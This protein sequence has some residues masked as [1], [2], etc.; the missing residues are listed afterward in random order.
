[1]AKRPRKAKPAKLNAIK[2][3]VNKDKWEVPFLRLWG[4]MYPDLPMPKRDYAF[5]AGRR[6]KY[7]FAWPS[8]KVAV[9]L[10][11][12]GGKSRHTTVAGH[13]KDCEK[14]NA[15]AA[16]GWRLLQYN[17]IRLKNDMAGIVGEVAE[18]VQ[19]AILDRA[20]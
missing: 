3:A 1:M 9:E 18:L 6:W 5:Y 14:M 17:V 16:T 10:H 15:G 7:D 19:S 12:G 20:A 8:L 4:M 2:N 13:A 11:G